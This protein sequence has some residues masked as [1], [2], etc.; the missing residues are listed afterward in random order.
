MA[1]TKVVFDGPLGKVAGKEWNLAVSTPTEALQM[2]EANKPGVMA[3]IRMNASKYANYRVTITRKNGRKEALSEETYKLHRSPPAVIRFTPITAGA[4]AVA[5][6]I[7]GVVLLVVAYVFPFTAP[8]LAPLGLSLLIGGLVE[9]LSPRPKT[10]SNSV[11]EDG[12][13]YYFNGAVNT[14]T[15]GP[16]VSLVYGR[17]LCGSQAVS[18]SITI[19][20]TMGN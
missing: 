18:A 16:P 6:V 13:S 14:S 9:M 3:W 4:S 2:V 20:Q 10:K 8:V 17:N 15:Q 1:L 12:T 19:D 7:V 5:R 11:N